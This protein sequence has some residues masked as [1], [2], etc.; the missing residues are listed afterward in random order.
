[1]HQHDPVFRWKEKDGIVHSLLNDFEKQNTD[2]GLSIKMVVNGAEHYELGSHHYCLTPSTYLVVNRHQQVSCSVRSPKLVEAF[3]F[4]LRP[5]MVQEVWQQYTT[6]LEQQLKRV[7]STNIS[8]RFHEKAYHLQENVL[9]KYLATLRPKLLHI[10]HTQQNYQKEALLYQLSEQL[11]G[12][13]LSVNGQLQALPA[14]RHTTKEELSRRLS[15]AYAYIA[16]HF[17]T[18]ITLEEVAK[19]AMLSKYHLLR[20]YKSFYGIT[21]YQHALQCR[22]AKAKNQLLQTPSK[23]ITTIALDAGYADRRTFSK[24]FKQAFGIAPTTYRK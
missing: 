21:P 16:D 14:T 15:I 9:G 2:S 19:A 11:I 10:A 6:T 13:H 7:D 17:Q 23:S 12:M 18:T 3:C 5:E 1:M 24:A 4:Y 20:S 22:L 8:L